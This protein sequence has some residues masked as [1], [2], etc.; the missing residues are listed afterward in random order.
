MMQ[1]GQQTVDALE[2]RP[3]LLTLFYDLEDLPRDSQRLRFPG[4]TLARREHAY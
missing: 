3:I 4:D 2:S 1:L